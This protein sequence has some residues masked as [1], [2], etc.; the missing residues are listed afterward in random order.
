MQD[1]EK[2]ERLIIELS[3]RLAVE[4]AVNE[5]FLATDLKD[6]DRVKTAF[7]SE[8]DFDMTSLAGGRPSTMTPQAI[9]DAWA[10]GLGP[11]QAVHHQTG[12]FVVR[13]DGDAAAASCYGTATHYKP[14]E[15]KRLTYFVGSYDFHLVRSSSGWKIDRFRFNKKYVE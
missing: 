15:A 4:D 14:E 8:V 7:A 10:E 12:N 3:D 9:A 1:T 6:W 11:V 5:L 2:A 13:V